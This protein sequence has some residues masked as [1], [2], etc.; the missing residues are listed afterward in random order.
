MK[1]NWF[2]AVCL[3][4][5]ASLYSQEDPLAK[6]EVLCP[7]EKNCPQGKQ[8]S[9]FHSQPSKWKK[10]HKEASPCDAPVCTQPVPIED[11][12]PC[13]SIT[14]PILPNVRCGS[15]VW[16]SADFIWWK[17][18]LE[19]T[20]Y[21]VTGYADNDF[22]PFGEN[23]PSGS[24]VYPDFHFEPGFKVGLGTFLW[25]DGWD[26]FA[27]YTWLRAGGSN[28][29]SAQPGSGLIGSYL[30][31]SPQVNQFLNV[32]QNASSHFHQSFNILDL[33]LG[34]KFFI[35]PHLILRPH[36][37]LKGALIYQTYQYNYQ[38]IPGFYEAVNGSTSFSLF[39]GMVKHIQNSGSIGIRSGLNT[40]WLF[41]GNLGIYGNIAASLLWTSFH[42][43]NRQATG[44]AFLG[45]TTNFHS[46][47]KV[48]R[49]VPVLELV[50]GLDYTMWTSE[51]RYRLEFFAGWEEQF[52]WS[53][54]QPDTGSLSLHGLTTGL[55]FT[56]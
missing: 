56:F 8:K 38:F 52:W 15:N 54:N 51:D 49:L 43:H 35:S 16:V 24:V 23:V 20:N 27:N 21:A 14:P 28:S 44:A 26:F 48:Q 47:D 5:A 32:A 34:R 2:A 6:C 45:T 19:N 30:V 41:W 55:N 12:L 42:S 53:F 31:T 4:S 3:F 11:A 33:E 39:N 1:K 25:H 29:I 18:F 7:L 9:M 13:D 40:D 37:G 46:I 36:L 22:A 10:R 17:T 50:L